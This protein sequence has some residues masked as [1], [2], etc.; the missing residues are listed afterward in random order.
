MRRLLARGGPA[1]VRPRPEL[2]RQARGDARHLPRRRLG[3]GHVPRSRSPSATGGAGD[4]RGPDRRARG[5]HRG[6]RLRRPAVLQHSGR[7]RPGVRAH[8]DRVARHPRGPGR[9]GAA[10]ASVV[11]GG[12][13]ARRRPAGRRRAG[14]DGEGR[15]GGRVRRGAPGRAGGGPQDPR[16]VAAA[17]AGGGRGGV[18]GPRRR[19]AR[20]SR[21]PGTRPCSG[22]GLRWGRSNPSWGVPPQVDGLPV[23]NRDVQTGE[24]P[25][26][27]AGVAA[28]TDEPDAARPD[29]RRRAPRSR[30]TAQRRPAR[31]VVDR[32]G[33]RAVATAL[34]PPPSTSPCAPSGSPCSASWRP[35]ATCRWSR[36]CAAG[37]PSGCSTSRTTATTTCPPCS[38][39]RSAGTRRT[40]RTRSSPAIPRRSP[41]SGC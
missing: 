16:R 20:A 9:R 14:A 25:R 6:G 38:S 28:S 33:L 2:L 35:G 4:G 36:R 24:R 22:T 15:R 18:A 41:P 34:P 32:G 1:P 19:R 13:R 31:R 39:T 12:H 10:R 17:G 3:H 26:R 29:R 30:T 27:A 8:R 40:R 5:A 21:R 11:G 37:T 23:Q 7:A